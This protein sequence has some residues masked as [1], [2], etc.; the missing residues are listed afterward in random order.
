[1]D[2]ILDIISLDLDEVGKH[3][4]SEQRK[5]LFEL[6]LQFD[7]GYNDLKINADTVK[8]YRDKIIVFLQKC[9]RVE[10][11]QLLPLYQ[12]L[13]TNEEKTNELVQSIDENTRKFGQL[14]VDMGAAVLKYNEHNEKKRA[15]KFS[16]IDNHYRETQKIYNEIVG[17]RELAI[18]LET[19]ILHDRRSLENTI[20]QGTSLEQKESE[21]RTHMKGISDFIELFKINY[22][23][24]KIQSKKSSKKTKNPGKE[25]D[26]GNTKGGDDIIIDDDYEGGGDNI[27]TKKPRKRGPN[28]RPPNPQLIGQAVDADQCIYRKDAKTLV[29]IISDGSKKTMLYMEMS[30]IPGFLTIDDTHTE[31]NFPVDRYELCPDMSK[32]DRY[33]LLETSDNLHS[34]PLDGNR[35]ERFCILYELLQSLKMGYDLNGFR[36]NMKKFNTLKYKSVDGNTDVRLYDKDRIKCTSNKRVII[37][38]L[39]SATENRESAKKKKKS[40]EARLNADDAALFGRLIRQLYIPNFSHKL[41][42]LLPPNAIKTFILPVDGESQKVVK[43][44]KNK[45]ETKKKTKKTKLITFNKFIEAIADAWE[46]QDFL[47]I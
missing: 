18:T 3:L 47:I 38:D 5:A 35:N 17:L 22:S 46:N 4:S 36:L 23:D 2:K 37:S 25:K 19:S 28:D 24:E 14:D 29:K 40:K 26:A 20:T 6:S 42:G 15:Y 11:D 45:K 41:I 13:V 44:R 43:K 10:D 39:S 21:I 27:I 9:I 1:M 8:K 34:L 32:K 7:V 12:P 30:V 33:V 16:E 31:D